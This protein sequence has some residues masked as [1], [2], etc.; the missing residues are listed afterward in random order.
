VSERHAVIRE[1]EELAEVGDA[2][3]LEEP[4]VVLPRV[5]VAHELAGGQGLHELEDGQV[6]HVLHL[7]VLTKVLVVASNHDTICKKTGIPF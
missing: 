5:L 4:V 2:V 6:G 3:R 7:G 1:V